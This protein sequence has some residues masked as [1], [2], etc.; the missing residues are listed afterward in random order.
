MFR[1]HFEEDKCLYISQYIYDN[2]DKFI[3]NNDVNN[4]IKNSTNLIN[5]YKQIWPN[6]NDK[7]IISN[8]KTCIIL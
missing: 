4:Y 6:L 8:N 7:Q 3:L 5:K 1:N 2:Y